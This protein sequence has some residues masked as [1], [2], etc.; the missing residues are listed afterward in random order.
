MALLYVRYLIKLFQNDAE[1]VQKEFDNI[2]SSTQSISECP[3]AAYTVCLAMLSAGLIY[4]ESGN[5]KA[6]RSS[7]QEVISA[8]RAAA[9]TMPTRK[10]ATFVELT[11]PFE[12]AKQATWALEIL[13]S[14]RADPANALTPEKIARTYSRLRTEES[15]KFM[16]D[17]I[18]SVTAQLAAR[19]QTL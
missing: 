6:A 12:T 10:P 8:F 11:I 16:A 19:A 15:W 14:G 13:R 3:I 17:R 5:E 4:A 18:R 2:A 1:G 7:W 9:A